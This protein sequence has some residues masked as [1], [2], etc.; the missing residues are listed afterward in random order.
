MVKG[1]FVSRAG[2]DSGGGEDVFEFAGADDGV[3]FGDVLLDFVAI[4][5]DEA[6][7]D[8]EFL[9]FAMRLVPGHLEDGVDRLL[10]GRVDEGA[11]VDDQDVGGF[12]VA[13]DARAGVVEQAHHDFAVDEV[14]GQ[15][16]E[17]KPTLL[18]AASGGV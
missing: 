12:G 3:D 9:G 18:C 7:G 5:L 11:G 14:F 2:C 10:L 4:A 17:T 1:E 6:S 16:S 8:D 15:P 13:D